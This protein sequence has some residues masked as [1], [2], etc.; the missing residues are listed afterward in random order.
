M[1]VRYFSKQSLQ[2]SI[3]SNSLPSNHS[4]RDRP[5]TLSLFFFERVDLANFLFCYERFRRWRVKCKGEDS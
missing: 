3:N 5:F 1:Q 4:L 2:Q